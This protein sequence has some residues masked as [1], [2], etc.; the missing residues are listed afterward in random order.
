MYKDKCY[1]YPPA[2]ETVRVSFLGQ[3][4]TPDGGGRDIWGVP[5]VATK[6]TGGMALPVPNNFILDDV[7][8]WRDVLK[9]PS[10]EGIDWEAMARKDTAHINREE[11][12]L[13]MGV[14]GFFMEFMGMM[15]FEEGLVSLSLEK[16]AV[17]ELFDYMADYY[18]V[19]VDAI[20]KYYKHDIFKVT[21]D[22]A[23]ANNPF[24]SPQMYR[25]MI[26]PYHVRIAKQALEA[27]LPILM[28]DCGRCEDFIEDWFDF[29][30]CGWD[31]AQVM[32]DL[33]GI[34]EKYA[35]KLTLCGCWDSSGPPG[36]AGSG[37]EVVRTAVRECADRYAPGGSFCFWA[38]VYGDPEDEEFTTRASWITDEYNNYVRPF[39]KKMG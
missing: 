19:F 16:E 9:P 17:L 10:L 4:R 35:G 22:T 20:M 5:Y 38:S 29:G 26:K 28:H 31:P 8:K 15:G 18:Q 33:D 2:Y 6:E 3:F 27:G 37:E 24:I 14:G 32:N 34:K 13:V 11:N 7:T 12:A 21:D 30:V 1:K 36:W 39:Y 23:T 25:E